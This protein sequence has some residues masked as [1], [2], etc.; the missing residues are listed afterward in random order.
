MIQQYDNT[1]VDHYL[2]YMYGS[3]SMIL[4]QGA[5]VTA[6]RAYSMQKMNIWEAHAVQ[7]TSSVREAVRQPPRLLSLFV[8]QQSCLTH[9]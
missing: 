1:D 3:T 5:R 2:N 7:V 4:Y 9:L 6:K 8:E